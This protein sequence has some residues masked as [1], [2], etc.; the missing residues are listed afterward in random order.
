ML[1]EE[2]K[3]NSKQAIRLLY[4][5]FIR[6]SKFSRRIGLKN[7]SFSIISNNC[8]GGY[9]YQY[10]GIKYNSPTEGLYF[11]TEDYVKLAQNP[12]YFFSKEIEFIS[13]GNSKNK[14]LL[15]DSVNWG[16]FPIGKIEDLEVYFLHYENETEA[17]EKWIRRV[18]RINYNNIYFL[19]TQ[20]ESFSID[21]LLKFDSIQTKHKICLTLRDYKNITCSKYI[22]FLP[23]SNNGN[24]FWTPEIIMQSLNWKRLLNDMLHRI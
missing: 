7:R 3:N 19:L 8:S 13:S 1:I 9:V 16:N 10:F 20:N 4:H 15:K 5:K 24:V 6:F 14:E 18:S 12:L 21:L 17:K 22:P 23:Q 2:I 11:T